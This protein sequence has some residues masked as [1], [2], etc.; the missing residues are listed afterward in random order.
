MT[1]TVGAFEAKTHLSALLQKVEAGE[2]ITI[3]KHGQPIA[4][5]VPVRPDAALRDWASFWETVDR[6]R[7]TLSPGVSVKGD[8]ESGRP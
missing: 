4:R 1:A 6:H 7:V 2:E 5:L 3:T 8:I